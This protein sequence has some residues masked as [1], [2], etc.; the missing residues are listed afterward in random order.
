MLPLTFADYFCAQHKIPLEQ[1]ESAVFKL[2]LYRRAV[3]FTGFLVILNRDH[4]TAD[5]DLIKAVAH[6]TRIRNFAVEVERFHDHP[7]NRGMLRWRFRMRISTTRLRGLVK[8]TFL[9][10]GVA[11]DGIPDIGGSRPSI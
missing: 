5:H 10:A 1:Y 11:P 8:A 6:L 9:Q 7:Y 2:L 4:F 3:P